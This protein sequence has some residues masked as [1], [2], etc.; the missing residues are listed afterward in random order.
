MREAAFYAV[1][2]ALKKAFEISKET[3]GLGDH[4]LRALAEMGHPYGFSHPAQIHDPDVLVHVQS[5]AYL[6]ALKA[7][8]PTASGGTIIEGSITNDSPLDRWIQEGTS[9]MRAR[10]WM[11]YIVDTY[12]DDFAALIEQRITN[13]IK[14]MAA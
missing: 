5:G 6:D 2:E 13:A 11:Q 14:G 3:I 12:G 10:P 1:I 9:I 8:S 7:N 4:S